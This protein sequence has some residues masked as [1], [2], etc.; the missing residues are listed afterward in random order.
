MEDL[1]TLLN[2][3]GLEHQEA[4][5][6]LAALRLGTS[7]ASIIGKR[8]EI[9][10]STARYTCEQLVKKQLMLATQK[11][12]TTLF[13]PENPSKL[14]KLLDLQK[15]QVEIKQQK[16]DFALQDLKRLFNPYAVIPKVRFYEG[17]GGLIDMFDDVLEENKILYGAAYVSDDIHPEVWQ[18]LQKSYVPRR[19][20]QKNEAYMLFNDNEKTKRYRENDQA[21]NR[22]SLLL[23]IES[24]PFE[25]CC[26]IYGNKV[27]FYSYRESDLTGVLIENE[28]VQKT[29]FSIF[30]LAW[31]KALQLAENQSYTGTKL[32][33]GKGNSR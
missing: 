8:C 16:L 21:M 9:P 14:Q 4:K 32:P 5:V 7:P 6:Y 30:Q 13:T 22:I 17:V 25:A 2:N 28:L 10:R 33:L 26:H 11:G 20:E 31:E 23:P 12:N 24:F 29:Q 19:K 27:A 15:E 18:Y 3:L 1:Q